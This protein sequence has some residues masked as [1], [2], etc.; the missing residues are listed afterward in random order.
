[1]N[2]NKIPVEAI[3]RG[4]VISIMETDRPF[5]ETFDVDGEII[6]IAYIAGLPI[7]FNTLIQFMAMRF[8][9]KTS[10]AM[11]PS[12]YSHSYSYIFEMTKA[13]RRKLT[14]FWKN[15][16]L[17]PEVRE[18]T[19]DDREQMPSIVIS[20]KVEELFQKYSNNE[21]VEPFKEL[22]RRIDED[23]GSSLLDPIQV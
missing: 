9:P 22:I 6:P 13:E 2:I 10:K 23:Y 21:T 18:L 19:K 15:I 17:S 3:R 4:T 16:E 1:M 20:Q 12:R 5:I 8:A 11:M 7:P 14:G